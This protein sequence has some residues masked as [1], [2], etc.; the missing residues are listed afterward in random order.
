VSKHTGWLFIGFVVV[1]A[2]VVI[3]FVDRN[4]SSTTTDT[5]SNVNA[6]TTVRPDDN[7][8]T[9]NSDY[10]PVTAADE[11]FSLLQVATTTE[12]G[13]ISTYKFSDGNSLS[14]MPQALQSAVLN[15][16]PTITVDSDWPVAGLMG[17]RYTLS[18]AKDG[19]EFHVVQVKYAGKLFDFRGSEDYLNNLDQYIEFTNN[20]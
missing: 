1:A 20:E 2:V 6:A 12:V 7:T 16:T 11:S 18:S 5:N 10:L 13:E 8:N 9:T 17:E 3:V 15:E 4:A 19:S 14:V